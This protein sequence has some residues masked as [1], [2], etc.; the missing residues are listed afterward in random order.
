[1]QTTMNNSNEGTSGMTIKRRFTTN[2]EDPF[3]SFDWITTDLE[4]RNMDGTVADNMLGVCFPSGFEGVPGTVAAQKYL[5]K[6]GV[7]AAQPVWGPYDGPLGA[8]FYRG[9]FHV[10]FGLPQCSGSR[11]RGWEWPCYLSGSRVG[12]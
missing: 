6:A 1:M 12:V 3:D 7:P 5:R 2:G 4:I 8:V 11:H 10:S 9:L